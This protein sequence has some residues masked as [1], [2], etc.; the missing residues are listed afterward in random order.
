MKTPL[1]FVLALAAAFAGCAPFHPYDP[2]VAEG[3]RT[4]G[5]RTEVVVE[6]GDG[7][8]LSLKESRRFLRASQ[9]EARVIRAHVVQ[10]QLNPDEGPI[11]SW[12]DSEYSRLLSRPRPLRGPAA[13][14]LQ[15]TLATLQMLR[16]VRAVSINVADFPTT[17][18]ANLFDTDTAWAGRRDDDRDRRHH[19]HDEDRHDHRPNNDHDHDRGHDDH[20]HDHEDHDHGHDH[21][22][23]GH[24]HNDH[25]DH[26]HDHNDNHSN[27]HDDHDHG[28]R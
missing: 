5:Q 9:A 11:L 27:D 6:D 8:R 26:G 10:C 14:R 18:D 23:H 19:D 20:H 28:H 21:D 3:L 7:G 25:D 17:A 4:L 2:V 24:D 15:N 22:D 12:L 13:V 16:P 1:W